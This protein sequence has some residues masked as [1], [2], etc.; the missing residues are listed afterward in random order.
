M[1]KDLAG[2]F[3]GRKTF[4]E[5]LEKLVPDFYE[6]IGQRLRAWA[7]PPPPIER[8]DAEP[9]SKALSGDRS[10]GVGENT[11]GDH[12]GLGGSQE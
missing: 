6:R 5:D 9:G 3:S 10:F 2:R 1:V 11:G 8:Q 12:G 7:P 4:V